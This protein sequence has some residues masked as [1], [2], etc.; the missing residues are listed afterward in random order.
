MFD[1]PIVL[2]TFKRTDTVLRILER[3]REIQPQKIYILSDQGRDDQEKKMVQKCRNE[4]ESAIDWTCEIVKNYAETNR[5][6]HANIGLGAKWVFEREKVAIFLE[7]DNLPELTFFEYCKELLEMYN[8]NT[9]VLWIC[10]TNYLG[11]YEPRNEASYMFTQHLL[12]CGWASWSHKFNKVY[13]DKLSLINDKYIINEMSQTY[14]DKKLYRQQLES[15]YR[16]NR[17]KLRGERF[18]SWDYH[19][20]L[21]IRAN[22]LVGIAPCKNQIK[23]I[24]VDGLST[25][26]G[27]TMTNI[28]TKRFCGMESF[29]LEIPLKHPKAVLIDSDFE[30][31]ISNIIL[32]PLKY[33]IKEKINLLLKR[34]MKIDIDDSLTGTLKRRF[35]GR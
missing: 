19:M 25:H 24:G 15:I 33:R 14:S 18:A 2:I 9:R 20:A 28:M 5:G 7:D 21:T 35:K 4:I 31:K 12:P 32:F 26:G 13:D 8:D 6:V 11:E 34:A 1:I 3:V 30:Q 10:G 16:E 27:N 29:P 23:N 22:D 17:R